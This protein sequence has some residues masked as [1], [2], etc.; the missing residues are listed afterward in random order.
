MSLHVI[1]IHAK[2]LLTLVSVD[3]Y[4]F[5]SK[6]LRGDMFMNIYIIITSCSYINSGAEKMDL[7]L[8]SLA[9][10]AVD[11]CLVPAPTYGLKV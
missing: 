10:L 6:L 9:T 7:Q 4:C 8:K 11:K 1:F 2:Q 5:V 3:T